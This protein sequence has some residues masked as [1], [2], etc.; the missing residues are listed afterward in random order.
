MRTIVAIMRRVNTLLRAVSMQ[1]QAGGGG[2]STPHPQTPSP[3]DHTVHVVDLF[4]YEA[5][6]VNSLEQLC[7]NW[8]AE[9][10]QQYYIDSLFTKTMQMCQ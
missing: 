5:N 1:S 2:A 9:K 4:G 8:S 7:I 10:L 3:D 6:D